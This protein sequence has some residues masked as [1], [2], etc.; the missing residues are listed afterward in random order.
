MDVR[1][2]FLIAVDLATL[3]WQE[4]TSAD[5][6]RHAPSRGGGMLTVCQG[7]LTHVLWLGVLPVCVTSVT[8][9]QEA[10]RTSPSTTPVV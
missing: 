8:R 2:M 9:A 3:G 6:M 5:S 7:S 4:A 1:V 10:L